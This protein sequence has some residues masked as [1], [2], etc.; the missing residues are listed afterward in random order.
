MK[1]QI[2]N[3]FIEDP[4]VFKSIKD[5]ITGETFY[6]L[7]KDFVNY[8]PCEGFKFTT[9]IINDSNLT[10]HIFINYLHM[11]KPLLEK[12]KHKKLHSVKFN[13]FTRTPKAEKYS[14]THH[15]K[16]TRVAL[17]FVNESSG[18]I[19][20]NTDFIAPKENQ[21]LSFNSD[22]P[23]KIVSPTKEKIFT[24]VAVNYE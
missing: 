17:L 22:I 13:L 20:I 1:H 19:E 23:Y 5:T 2:L 6:W 4:L 18:G 11:V 21:L 15:K 10:Q 24:Y 9:E 3:N 12:I 16:D 8:R 14:I 7:Y